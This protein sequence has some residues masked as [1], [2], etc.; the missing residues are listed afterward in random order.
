M[1]TL[2]I[3]A[4]LTEARRYFSTRPTNGEDSAHW[5][6][7]MNSEMCGKIASWID[8]LVHHRDELLEA[9]TRYLLRARASE[10]QLKE[11][12]ELYEHLN[13]N[14]DHPVAKASAEHLKAPWL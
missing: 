3:I 1:K 6:N 5:S 12:L 8:R 2:D 7:V 9:N 13:L 4:W 11:L 10:G 14:M